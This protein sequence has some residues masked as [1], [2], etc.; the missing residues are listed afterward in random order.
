LRLRCLMTRP[1]FNC[2]ANADDSFL[3]DFFRSKIVHDDGDSE[4]TN[5]LGDLSEIFN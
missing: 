2:L 1:L 4:T 3:N 5:V